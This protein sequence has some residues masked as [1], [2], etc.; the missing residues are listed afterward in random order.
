MEEEKSFIIDQ[1]ECII[2][3]QSSCEVKE[4]STNRCR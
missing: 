1:D 3:L 4:C 2:E